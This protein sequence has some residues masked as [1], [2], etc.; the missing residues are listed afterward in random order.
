V[1]Q[2]SRY[3][4]VTAVK[5]EDAMDLIGR[6]LLALLFLAGA[7]QKAMDPT[8]VMGLLAGLG[9]PVWLVWPA[10]VFDAVV[11]IMLL[12][13]RTVRL[14]AMA[15]AAYCLVTSI[16][17]FVPGDGWQMSILVKNWALAGGFLVLASAKRPAASG[18]H[19]QS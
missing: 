17:H 14:A 12:L 11:A 4:A 18:A 3:L 5:R 8:I 9:W 10:L 19:S 13:S 6:V 7:A 15:A 2:L 1:T 16:F